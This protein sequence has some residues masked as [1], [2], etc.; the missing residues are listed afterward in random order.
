MIYGYSR[1]SIN[2][3]GLLELREVTLSLS[4]E[5][6]RLL[7]RFLAQMAEEL[8][9]DASPSSSWHRHL[10]AWNPKWSNPG[11]IADVV[12]VRPEDAG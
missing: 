4:P 9:S 3:Y 5:R 1:A 11:N 12:V 2:E 8:E 6:L 10:S 7:A